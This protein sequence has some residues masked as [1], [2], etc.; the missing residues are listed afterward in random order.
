MDLFFLKDKLEEI[1][2]SIS[3][4][5][6]ITSF[7]RESQPLVIYKSEMYS[8][9]PR[10][11]FKLNEKHYSIY[12]DSF[13]PTIKVKENENWVNVIDKGLISQIITFFLSNQFSINLEEETKTQTLQESD[14]PHQESYRPIFQTYDSFIKYYLSNIEF[15]PEFRDLGAKFIEKLE[16]NLEKILIALLEFVAEIDINLGWIQALRDEE[17][18]CF[19]IKN[20]FFK[21][22]GI[23]CP[24]P[25]N[26]CVNLKIVEKELYI[27]GYKAEGIQSGIFVRTETRYSNNPSYL[28]L[29]EL[30]LNLGVF[31]S[32]PQYEKDLGNLIL[33][34]IESL[35][36]SDVITKA[37]DLNSFLR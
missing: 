3:T 2:Q 19:V 18:L 13:C 12:L 4:A 33:T 17:E 25:E 26:A 20:K 37:I 21:F 28:R 5:L 35:K 8:S 1:N 6:K 16:F 31:S 22:S 15:S 10:Y 7:I 14:S 27:L 32:T 29:K 23:L 34:I 30:V 24:L 36:E 11:F 9:F